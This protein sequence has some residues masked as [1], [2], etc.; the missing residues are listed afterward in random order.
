MVTVVGGDMKSM[1]EVVL[2]RVVELCIISSVVLCSTAVGSMYCGEL[3]DLTT[4][5]RALLW[6]F[7]AAAGCDFVAI[8]TVVGAVD[9][10]WW[11]EWGC[12]GTR[13]IGA[14]F[15]VVTTSI[16]GGSWYSEVEICCWWDIAPLEIL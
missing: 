12:W 14:E 9:I 2:V 10:W 16:V 6:P 8:V 15:V 13:R 7:L 5:T 3:S 4:V 11:C 1:E